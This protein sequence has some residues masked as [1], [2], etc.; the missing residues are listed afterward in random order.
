MPKDGALT[1]AYGAGT[2][3]IDGKSSINPFTKLGYE[4]GYRTNFSIYLNG[5]IG[6]EWSN[7]GTNNGFE[8]YKI[9]MDGYTMELIDSVSRDENAYGLTRY[10]HDKKGS[11][12]ISKDE[13]YSILNDYIGENLEIFS[14][15]EI[16]P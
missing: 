14:W 2:I 12:E 3:T 16:K 15:I 8:F 11:I 9:S 7:S 13:F 6:I 4:F 10:Y 1:C 5:I